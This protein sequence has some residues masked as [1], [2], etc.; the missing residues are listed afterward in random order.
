MASTLQRHWEA[1]FEGMSR[2]ERSGGT[3]HAYLPDPLLDWDLLLPADVSADIADAET[4]IRTLNDTAGHINLEGLATFLL[5]SESV[6]SSKIEGVAPGAR[7]M[8]RAETD[9]ALAGDS[10]DQMAVELI[11]NI[12]AMK[13]AI[14]LATGASRFELGDLLA[15]HRTLMD[16]SPTPHLGGV[17]RTEQNWIG[18]NNFNPVGAAFV[19]PPPEHLDNLLDDLI[20]YINDDFHSP[21]VQAGIA[22]AQF[23]TLHP[24]GDGNGRTGRA[25]I[26][27]V[28]RRRGLAPRL[29]PPIS[30]AL[31]AH[32]GGYVEGL[33]AFRH[34]GPSDSAER[35]TAAA[36]WLREFATAAR[37][38]C[39][40]AE[41]HSV[42]IETLISRWR[43]KLGGVRANSSTALLVG[44]L[45]G[46]PIVT[47]E[48]AS[49]LIARSKDRTTEA[50]NSL[51][52]AGILRQRNV[53]KQ[54]YRV[55]EAPEVVELFNDL[56]KML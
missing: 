19:P 16:K 29:V 5:R 40:A 50:I 49:K 6:G 3:Y 56:E 14:A 23:E 31:A 10:N 36:T 2:Q 54:R 30:N 39:N 11:G 33:I 28:L 7:R 43:V 48:T 4:A 35:S 52:E 41:Q 38:A 18:G 17:V 27:V 24:F 47:A 8:V 20:E 12:D 1:R 32:P 26:H 15:I 44:V 37:L 22:H 46:T 45:P 42:S 34:L 9:I 13:S 25:L 51:V 53:H 21:M 55:F